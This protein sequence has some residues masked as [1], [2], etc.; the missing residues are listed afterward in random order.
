MYRVA[1]EALA[2]AA[3]PLPEAPQGRDS[4]LGRRRAAAERVLRG[5]DERRVRQ[6]GEGGGAGGGGGGVLELF[7]K[8][9][10]R[11]LLPPVYFVFLCALRGAAPRATAFEE[12]K[13]ESLDDLKRGGAAHVPLKEA[14]PPKCADHGDPMKIIC[15]DCNRLICRDCTL[16]V[17]NGHSYDFLIN[18][19]TEARKTLRDALTPLQNV[20]ANIAGA[21]KK[22]AG[23]E[24][25][26]GNQEEVCKSI[27]QSFHKLRAVLEKR[28]TEL[29][30]KVL[31]LTQEKEDA[32]T[33]QRKGLQMAQTEIQS[34]VDFVVRNVDNTSAQ[35]LMGILSQLQ[36]K[37]EGGEK[38]HQQLSLDP[39]TTADIT[40]CLPFSEEIPRD[41]GEVFRFSFTPQSSPSSASTPLQCLRFQIIKIQL[42]EQGC[43]L[44]QIQP[45]QCRLTWLERG[46][47]S[48]TSPTPLGSGVDMT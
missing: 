33:A 10:S 24:A 17:Q 42:F 19:A 16:I 25:Q 8:R 2:T 15:L 13:V 46:R 5:E 11:F 12:H 29:V 43:N 27:Q 28:E 1:G 3:L 32:L 20:L 18:C 7:Q 23:A 44:W 35:D 4:S 34:L 9:E 36:S 38:R 21:D 14:P 48:T 41:L 6:N 30:K 26:V 37:V 47:G 22:L 39:A 31:T 45:L 40:C